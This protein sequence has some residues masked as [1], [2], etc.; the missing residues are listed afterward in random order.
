MWPYFWVVLAVVLTVG[1]GYA[2]NMLMRIID[3]RVERAK[4]EVLDELDVV[5][6]RLVELEQERLS[7]GQSDPTVGSLDTNGM[8]DNG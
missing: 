7:A 6:Q 8:T 3:D 1:A 2:S 5:E 4:R